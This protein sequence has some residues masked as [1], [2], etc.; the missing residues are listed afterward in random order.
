MDQKLRNSKGSILVI[1]ILLIFTMLAGFLVYKFMGK[2]NA[3]P[4]QTALS[5]IMP[6]KNAAMK[7]SPEGTVDSDLSNV[8]QTLSNLDM[9]LKSIDDSM[10]DKIGD[11]SE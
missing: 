2:Y 7:T 10:N 4:S 8:D 11:L 5:K 1:V 6:G 9:D 3:I